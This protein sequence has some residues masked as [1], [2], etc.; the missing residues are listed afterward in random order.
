[1]VFFVTPFFAIDKLTALLMILGRVDIGDKGVL[2]LSK[3]THASGTSTHPASTSSGIMSSA[4]AASSSIAS[5]K[6]LPFNTNDY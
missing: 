5:G 4:S 6:H 1:M 3:A 2:V